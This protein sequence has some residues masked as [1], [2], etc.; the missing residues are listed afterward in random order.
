MTFADVILPI[1][2]PKL[3]TYHIPAQLEGKVKT[4][5][6]VI[7]QIRKRLYTG[8]VANLHG[9]KPEYETKE[10]KEIVDE[11][12]FLDK[13]HIELWQWIADYYMCTPGEVF[14]AAL[15]PSLRLESNQ[16]IFLVAEQAEAGLTPEEQLALTALKKKPLTIKELEK[17]TSSQNILK[18]VKSLTQKG[19]IAVDQVVENPF[20]PKKEKFIK[21][22]DSIDNE[23]KLNATIEKL[24]RAKKQAEILLRYITLARPDFENPH[25][26]IPRKL[27]LENI[28]NGQ[29]PLKALIDKGIL[30]EI[31][32]EVSRFDQGKES[33]QAKELSEAQTKALE[34]IRT[35]FDTKD[36]TLLFGVTSSGKTEIYIRLIQ[37]YLDKGKQ[38][39]YLLPEIALTPQIINRLQKVFG[40]RVG[41]YHSKLNDNERAEI[42]QRING[43]TA[44]TPYDIIVGVRSAIFLPF[45]NLGLIIVDEEHENT[46]KQ[47]DPAPRYN[48]RDL[49]I[50]IARQH[51]AKVLLGTATPSIETFYNAQKGKYGFVELTERYENIELPEI[52][53][54]DT[55]LAYQKKQMKGIFHPLLLEEIGNAL[56]NKEQVILFRNRRGFAPFV[57]CQNCGWIPKCKQCDVSL[58]YHK[59]DNKLVCHY[60]GYSIEVPYTCKACGSTNMKFRSFGTERIEDELKIYY[61][62]ATIQRLDLD[63]TRGKNAHQKIIES[64]ENREIDILVG[65]QMVTKGLDFDN[66]S[67]V[68]ILNADS[69][70]NYP[71]FRAH[72]RAYMLM[73]QVS[74]RAGRKKKRGKVIIQTSNPAHPVFGYVIEN[75]YRKMYSEIMAERQMF[76]YPPI[77]RLIKIGVKHK[78]QAMVEVFADMLAKELRKTLNHR[79]LGPEYPVVKKVQN[80]FRKDIIIKLEKEISPSKTKKYIRNTVTRLQATQNFY[81][82]HIIFDVDP[83]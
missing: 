26:E 40:D 48:A 13:R 33:G 7:I 75:D 78:D 28:K 36:V 76:N 43:Q 83:M 67:I 51:K 31:E 9:N 6:R 53:L 81:K 63:T 34:E 2:S 46:Y 69:M 70:L 37:E 60:C 61:P 52:I 27:L 11:E 12:P 1:I 59:E 8:I 19:L 54:A 41:I 5:Q 62:E 15:P 44:Q 50:I 25:K 49:A 79:V 38:I 35:T 32:K 71:D 73:T 57:E 24:L 30:T 82:I 3:Y 17:K 16:K 20:K 42:W 56:N 58:T 23:Q 22:A 18:L 45:K 64:F 68:G 21:L 66:V 4:G 10:I 29:A 74:G 55:K 80:W 14:M 77:T 47:F 65:T 72:E 39:L